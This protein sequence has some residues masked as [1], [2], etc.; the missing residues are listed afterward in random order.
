M[1]RNDIQRRRRNLP[2]PNKSTGKITKEGDWNIKIYD[3]N[4]VNKNTVN[5]EGPQGNPAR[6]FTSDEMGTPSINEV[7]LNHWQGDT[8]DK[9]Y[10][11]ASTY[12]PSA[13]LAS[14]NDPYLP[15]LQETYLRQITVY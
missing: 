6:R 11:S 3:E 5:V 2:S 14:Y 12:F 15:V 13:E 1:K 7:H 9:P 4:Y 8:T 10:K